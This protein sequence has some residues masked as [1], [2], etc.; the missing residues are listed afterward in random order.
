MSL[1]SITSDDTLTLWD[2]VFDDLADGTTV[3]AEFQSDKADMKTG[4]NKNTIVARN[5]QGNNAILTLRV[6]AGSSDDRF[7]SSKSDSQDADFTGFVMASGSFIKKFGDGQG[8]RVRAVYTM[9]GGA[10]SKNV[11][12]QE[13]VE[14]NTDQGVAVYTMKFAVCKRNIQ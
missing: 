5:E 13:N 2:R 14:G 1:V 11:G 8:N 10:F 9:N 6:V 7:L 12:G 4:K 3:N